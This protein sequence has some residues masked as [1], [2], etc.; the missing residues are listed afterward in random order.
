MVTIAPPS[1]ISGVEASKIVSSKMSRLTV[2]LCYVLGPST[3]KRCYPKVGFDLLDQTGHGKTCLVL[4]NVMDSL[5][6]HE[7]LEECAV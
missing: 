7:I 1:Y 4:C 6:G 3:C 5:D 2:L